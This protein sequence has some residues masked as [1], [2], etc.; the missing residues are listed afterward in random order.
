MLVKSVKERLITSSNEYAARLEY[1]AQKRDRVGSD[2]LEKVQAQEIQA[3]SVR[4]Q[5]N[6][7]TPMC[8]TG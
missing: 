7:E 2:E 5:V 6:V 3:G 8:C 1:A 4:G